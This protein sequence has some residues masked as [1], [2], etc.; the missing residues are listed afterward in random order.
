M[1]KFIE[2]L[3][4]VLKPTIQSMGFNTAKSEQARPR[5]QLVMDVAI[6]KSKTQLKELD[7]ADALLVP[8]SAV[9]VG[10]TISGVQLSKG[11]A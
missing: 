6:G 3:Q 5:I 1:S 8:I 4:Q 10:K 2:R 11:D 7:K 9:G